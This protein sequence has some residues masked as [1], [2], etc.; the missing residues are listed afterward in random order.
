MSIAACLGMIKLMKS[1]NEDSGQDSRRSVII[2]ID[3]NRQQE[4]FDQ[5]HKFAE[6]HGFSIS[7]DTLSSSN[8][9]F[10]IYMKREDVFLSGASAFEPGEFHIGFYDANVRHPASDSVFDDLV[11]ELERFVSEVPD[12]QFFIR[13]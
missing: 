5:L 1:L 2:T 4:F 9:K 7:I 3:L 10:Q 8:E 13:K 12:T 6:T 11:S